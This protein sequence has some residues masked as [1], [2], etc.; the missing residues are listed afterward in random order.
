[1]GGTILATAKGTVRKKILISLELT[2][3]DWHLPCDLSPQHARSVALVL[4][5]KTGLGVSP[6][7]H[8]EFD[9]LFETVSEKAGNKQVDSRWQVLSGLRAAP[10]QATLTVTPP[11]NQGAA[12]DPFPD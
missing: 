10:K 1:M 7:F 9:D 3:E 4:N 6:Q 5:I 8:V 12:G 11:G 2:C